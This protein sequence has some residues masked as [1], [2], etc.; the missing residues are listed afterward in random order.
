MKKRNKDSDKKSFFSFTF[1][2]NLVVGI[3]VI[4]LI[5]FLWQALVVK[6]QDSQLFRIRS[7][8]VSDPSMQ[9]I[10]S[11]R[12]I[13]LK[14]RN[15]FTVNLNSFA[16]Q[17]QLQYPEIAEIKLLK[18]FPDQIV[19]ATKKRF[20]FAQTR[21]RNKDVTLDSKGIV[22]SS[23]TLIPEDL[24]LISGVLAQKAQIVPGTQLQSEELKIALEVIKIFRMN[25][26]LSVYKILRIDVT[27]LSQIEFYLS[28]SLKVI[29]DQSNI[30]EKIQ[31]LSLILS[32]AKLKLEEVNSIDVRFKEPLI[33]FKE[34]MSG[35]KPVN[36]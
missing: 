26:Y 17:L 22:L 33:R 18:R 34:S 14:G 9:Y 4:G 15:I 25:K 35:K 31:L 11:S 13:N 20:P 6:V 3:L 1:F 27:N 7:I 8:K 28:D 21:I 5:S 16:R 12:L 32:Q 19:V 29:I 10:N 36:K 2:K 23:S 24:P 30:P